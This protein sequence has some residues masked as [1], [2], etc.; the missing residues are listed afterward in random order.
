MAVMHE[1]AQP[2]PIL[3]ILVGVAILPLV[4]KA[5]VQ[6]WRLRHIPGPWQAKLTNFWL[7]SKIWRG[8]EFPTVARELDKKYGRVVAYGPNRVLFSEPSAVGIIMN[9]KNPLPKV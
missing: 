2:V 1:I 7:A 6:H 4:I 5:L 9:T 8:G 3:V